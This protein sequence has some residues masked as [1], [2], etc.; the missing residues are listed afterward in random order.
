MFGG[1]TGRGGFGRNNVLRLVGAFL[2]GSLTRHVVGNVHPHRKPGL[3]IRAVLCDEMS[4]RR[5]A[6]LAVHVDFRVA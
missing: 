1:S 6:F 5:G 2:G 3:G 4:G